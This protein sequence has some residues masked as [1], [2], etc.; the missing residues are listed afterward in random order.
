MRIGLL[1]GTF[2]PIHVGHLRL[3]RAAGRALR[4][5][6]MVFVPA[7]QPWHKTRQVTPYV[8][9]Y[10]MLALALAGHPHWR[11]L[12]IPPA[13]GDD[14][15]TYSVDEVGWLRSKY[16][17]DEIFFLLGADAF[18]DL[19]SWKDYQRLLRMCDFILVPRAGQ[20]LTELAA[21]LPD[22][23]IRCV[24]ADRIELATG[25]NI[26][27]LPRFRSH[28]S[29]TAVRQ[30]LAAGQA[31]RQVPSAVAEYAC[32]AELYRPAPAPSGRAR[33]QAVNRSE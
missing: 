13:R 11:P 28:I 24:H 32:R 25:R 19:P 18:H 5:D 23:M 31:T 26:H 17:G 30:R 7:R 12:S 4:L 10:A 1:G 15:P 29:S 16:P 2:D 9:R 33:T 21:V 20:T 22:D 14:G 8:D 6:R 27:W 3:A